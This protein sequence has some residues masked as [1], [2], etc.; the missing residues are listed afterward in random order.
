MPARAARSGCRATRVGV[1]TGPEP[2]RRAG[3]HDQLHLQG[4]DGHREIRVGM[5][6]LE[7][8]TGGEVKQQGYYPDFGADDDPTFLESTADLLRQQGY[9]VDTALDAR[10]ARCRR[11]APAVTTC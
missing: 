3:W 10:I 7:A 9:E 5:P 8:A 6:T 1:T 4:H 2:G 11:Y